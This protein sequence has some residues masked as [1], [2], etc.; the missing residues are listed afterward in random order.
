MIWGRLFIGAILFILASQ[1]GCRI[2][3]YGRCYDSSSLGGQYCVLS[4]Y[5]V[6]VEYLAASF[7]SWFLTLKAVA[8]SIEKRVRFGT[9]VLHVGLA[10]VVSLLLNLVSLLLLGSADMTCSISK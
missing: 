9:F 2:G 1:L 8:I 6:I 10:T 3:F 4:F 5:H 7:L